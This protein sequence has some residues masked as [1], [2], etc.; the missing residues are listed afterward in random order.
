MLA[1]IL[2]LLLAVLGTTAS[3]KCTAQDGVVVGTGH[4]VGHKVGLADAD[5]CC[6]LCN[7]TDSCAAWTFHKSGEQKGACWLHS[8]SSGSRADPTA[9]SGARDG[10]CP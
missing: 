8:S 6:A 4:N 3:Q 5:S 2:A 10:P 7:K 1:P 9:V